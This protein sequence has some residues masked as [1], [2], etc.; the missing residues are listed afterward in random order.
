VLLP[1][2][3]IDVETRNDRPMLFAS[4]WPAR[5][6]ESNHHLQTRKPIATP[7][8][9]L[10]RGRRRNLR[11]E[12]RRNGRGPAAAAP[13]ARSARTAEHEAA[14]A[15]GERIVRRNSGATIR[16]GADA[17]ERK[18]RPW[19]TQPSIC[20]DVSEM[21]VTRSS[22]GCFRSIRPRCTRR[23]CRIIPRTGEREAPRPWASRLVGNERQPV[24][25]V[26]LRR[27]LERC[28]PGDPPRARLSSSGAREHE[29]HLES[30]VAADGDDGFSGFIFSSMEELI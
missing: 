15:R 9:Q 7:I 3:R 1:A 11:P 26:D 17:H 5:P 12:K 30:R 29:G 18:R 6:S 21:G 28:R 27:G 22:R 10:L 2:Q 14:K 23:A 8:S 13:P 4:S 25:L 16:A 20:P 19:A 24:H